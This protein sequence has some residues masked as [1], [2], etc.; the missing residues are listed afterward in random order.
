MI[1]IKTILYATDFS[2]CSQPACA[3]A[4]YLVELTGAKLISFHSIG[5]SAYDTQKKFMQQ[6]V[7]EILE[8]KM[9]E[10]AHEDMTNFCQKSF[11]D[12]DHQIIISAGKPFKEI[13]NV[14]KQVN[15]DLIIMGAHGITGFTHAIIG[16]T[17][18]RVIRNS[19][20]PVLT[21]RTKK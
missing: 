13:L 4:K 1:P 17:A 2:D 21:I 15:A 19:T 18:E 14:A 8:K 11:V 5:T 16:S 10:T 7:F 9:I 3:H 6:D 20:I 12:F